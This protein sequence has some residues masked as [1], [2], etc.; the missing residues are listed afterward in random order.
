[1]KI[2]LYEQMGQDIWPQDSHT[3]YITCPLNTLYLLSLILTK[4]PKTLSTVNSEIHLCKQVVGSSPS[5]ISS[6]DFFLRHV[7]TSAVRQN[8]EHLFDCL[9][10]KILHRKQHLVATKSL[11]FFLFFFFLGV[12]QLKEVKTKFSSECSKV[13]KKKKEKIGDSKI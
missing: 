7:D 8:Q 9:R 12:Q 4:T 3:T 13:K 5:N 1:M 6:C 2:I 10:L 11:Q